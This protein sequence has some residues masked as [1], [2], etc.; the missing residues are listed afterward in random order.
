MIKKI[1]I[2][3]GLI[4]IILLISLRLA[5]LHP[6]LP[7]HLQPS[8]S[9]SPQGPDYIGWKEYINQDYHYQVKYPFNWYFHESGFNPPPPTT[10]RISNQPEEKIDQPHVWVEIFADPKQGRTLDNYEEIHSLTNQGHIAQKLTVDKSPAL[11]IDNIGLDGDH[12]SLY[13]DHGDYIYRL[14]WF[15]S[16]PDIRGQFKDKC[17]AI[18]ASISFLD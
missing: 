13:I 12:A 7:Q 4:V 11:L 8:P 17:L 14:T 3:L 10:V 18:M 5:T 1:F 9:P 2:G 16:R 15:G 6:Q